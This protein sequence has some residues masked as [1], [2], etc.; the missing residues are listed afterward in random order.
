MDAQEQNG[1]LTQIVMIDGPQQR[2]QPAFQVLKE[3]AGFQV[4]LFSDTKV[5]LSNL[6]TID[7]LLLDGTVANQPK[8]SQFVEVPLIL[9]L[10]GNGRGDLPPWLQAAHVHQLAYPHNPEEL[11]ATIADYCQSRKTDAGATASSPDHLA[12]LFGIAQTLS[13]QFDLQEL[14]ER[15]L[16]LAPSL[17]GSSASI[18][19]RE[20]DETLYYR[21]TIPGCEELSGPAGQ[22]FAQRLLQDGLEGWVLTHNRA[23]IIANTM[24]DDRWFRASYLPEL[25][26][27][28][29]ALP[30]NLDRVE[31]RGVYTV[32]HHQPEHFA[33]Q[34]LNLFEA[35]LTQIGLAIENALLFKNQSERSVQLA[36]INE[37]SQAATSI[38]NL[39]LMLRT[40]VQAIRRS[41]A[42]YSVAI[43]LFNPTTQQVELRARVTSDQQGSAPEATTIVHKLREGLIGWS[44]A[45]KETIL[46]NDT[47]LDPRVVFKDEAKEVRSE[48]CV[49][50][51]LGVKVIGVLDLRSTRLGA[52]D[53]HHVSALEMLVDQLAIAIE[54]ARLYDEINRRVQELKSLNEI[55]QAVNSTLNLE[56]TLTLITDHTT[57]LM[58]VAAA[59]VAL[60]DEASNE[61]WFAAA[62][63]EGSE[64]VIGL[65]ME[66]GQGLAGWVAQSG[67]PVI[68]PDVTKDPRFFAEVDESS[69]FRTRS[70]LCV[71][72]QTKGQTIGAIEVMNKR[73]GEFDKEDQ[74]LLQALAVSAATAIENSRLYEEKVNTIDRLAEA[75]RQN[76]RLFQ[77]A[78]ALRAF[79]EDIIQNMTNG[80]IAVDREQRIT[81]FNPAAAS[82]LGCATD[83]V[84][85]QPIQ[86]AMSGAD[87]L[88]QIF[89]ATLATGQPQAHREVTVRHWDGTQL[90][91]SV[92][93]ALLAADQTGSGE[94]GVVGVLEDL[95]EIKALE[96]ERRRLDRL[97]ALGEMSAVVAHEIRNPMAGIGAGIEY[98]TR[99]IPKDSP[100]NEGVKLIQGE[101]TRVNR[102]LEDILFVA[103]PLQL[104]LSRENL[105]ELIDSVLRRY[106]SQLAANR[107]TT[108]T[109]Y[110]KNLPRLKVDRQRLEQVLANLVINANQAMVEGGQLLVELKVNSAGGSKTNSAVIMT[111]ADTGPGIPSETERRIFEPFFTTKTKGTGLG[112]PV[113]RRIIDA[114]GGHIDVE[115]QAGQGTRFIISLPVARKQKL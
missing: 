69:G 106:E 107:V 97:A 90:P 19:V 74:A 115:S 92:S 72:L 84:L 68:V 98:L 34:N 93:T 36:L 88:I 10:T 103:R 85:N 40:V 99:N 102:I 24:K 11:V 47:S 25:E 59:S 2:L 18:L 54:N 8:S 100:D 3:R 26:Y 45:T 91:I 44:A 50:I 65:R 75:E 56:K 48:L 4:R 70:I 87:E 29:V 57:R 39:D 31:A 110:D 108:V 112:L 58:D 101:I 105:A 41:F 83:L 15:I 76:A 67:Q 61:V 111:V 30:F 62:F 20:R 17:G 73:S 96:A 46:A 66:L 55:G 13:G 23:A 6:S 71:P 37:V 60:R 32:G 80:L 77:Q 7:V 89:K 86:Q 64:A 38:L 35:A 1:G 114:H 9:I 113:A 94:A 43:H 27:S 109:N 14:F 79:N 33:R 12:L 82:M 5:D 95:S 28:V 49:P 22:H 104:N 63:G 42:F 16:A 52:F 53:R 21:S 78:E 81:A 51:T